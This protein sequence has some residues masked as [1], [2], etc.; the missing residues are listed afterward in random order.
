MNCDKG[1]NEEN[2]CVIMICSFFLVVEIDRSKKAAGILDG[3]FPLSS[4][5]VPIERD[6]VFSY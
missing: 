2:L 4:I 1:N 5:S 3:I 6:S